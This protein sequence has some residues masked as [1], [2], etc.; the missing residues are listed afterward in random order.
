MLTFRDLRMAASRLLRVAAAGLVP[1]F[2]LL[3]VLVARAGLSAYGAVL[4]LAFAGTWLGVFTIG[5][6]TRGITRASMALLVVVVGVR[7]VAVR[8]SVVQAVRVHNGVAHATWLGAIVDERDPAVLAAAFLELMEALPAGDR[9]G[10]AA[11]LSDGYARLA[12]DVGFVPTVVPSALLTSDADDFDMITIE[13]PSP[14]G[15]VVFLHGSGGAFTLPCWQVA[16][17]ARAASLSTWCPGTSPQAAWM[18]APGK[19]IAQRAVA[20]ARA[21]VPGGVVVGVGLSAGGIGLTALGNELDVDGVIAISGTA[22]N[23][24]PAT[25]HPTLLIHGVADGMVSIDTARSLV[26]ADTAGNT[27]LVARPGNH[28]L[29]LQQ[30]AEVGADITKRLL[31][32]AAARAG[33]R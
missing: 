3:L 29:L 19:E 15:V 23:A 11:T 24:Q 21:H 33:N 20:L 17:A 14:H 2:V 4:A 32:L 1:L 31:Q 27:Q 22:P 5:R 13:A 8:S 12:A 25:S 30:H 10:I 18:R 16:V 28:F 9:A 6:R 26:R 7:A